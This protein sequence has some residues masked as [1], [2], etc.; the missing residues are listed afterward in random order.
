MNAAEYL[1]TFDNP[2]NLCTMLEVTASFFAKLPSR[3]D[4]SDEKLDR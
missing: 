3:N 1:S 4:S 2:I